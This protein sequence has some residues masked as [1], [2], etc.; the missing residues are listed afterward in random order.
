[1]EIETR[2]AGQAI[3][4]RMLDRLYSALSSGPTLNCRPGHSRQRLDLLELKA[5]Q[6]LSP[7]ETLAQLLGPAAKVTLRARAVPPPDLSDGATEEEVAAHKKVLEGYEQQTRALKKLRTIAEDA[8]EYFQDTG[9]PALYIGYPLL[10]LPPDDYGRRI[11]GRAT[12][13]VLAP[14][15]LVPV[16]LKVLSGRTPGVEIRCSETGADRLIPNLALLAWVERQTGRRLPELDTDDSGENAFGELGQI[17]QALAEAVGVQPLELG[18]STEIVRAPRSEPGETCR[19]VASAVI[20]LYPLPNQSILC[21]VRDMVEG[22]VPEGPINRFLV[23][24]SNALQERDPSD[25][26]LRGLRNIRQERCI[27]YADPCQ[28]RAV[29][30]ARESQVLVVHGPPGTGKS[31]TIANVIGDHLA[32]GQRVLM[33]CDKRTALDVVHHR[34]TH[35]GLGHL[36]AVV[37][38]AQRDRRDLYLQ[39]REQLDRLATAE[40]DPA[41][42]GRLRQ[43]DEELES[44]HAEMQ[45]YFAQLS[46]RPRPDAMTFTELAGLWVATYG[47][48]LNTVLLPEESFSQTRPED[49]AGHQAAIREALDRGLRAGFAESPW[50]DALGVRLQ[51][52]VRLPVQQVKDGVGRVAELATAVDRTL[53]PDLLPFSVDHCPKAQGSA[54]GELARRLD[55]AREARVRF[56]GWLSRNGAVRASLNELDLAAG[57]MTL[58]S[59]TPDDRELRLSARDVD[60]S[61]G[62]VNRDLQTLSEYRKSMGLWYGA[63]Q[64]GIR[65]SGREVL[66]RFGLGGSDAEAGRLMTFLQVQRATHLLADTCRS[67][68]VMLE[69]E[70]DLDQPGPVLTAA[71]QNR[72]A[73]ET[74]QFLAE[75]PELQPVSEQIRHAL[76]G[77]GWDP[78]LAGL[79][80]SAPRAEALAELDS[81]VGL[82]PVIS[83][84]WRRNLLRQACESR[85]VEGRFAALA[86]GLPQLEGIVRALDIADSLP[87]E[88]NKALRNRLRAGLDAEAGYASLLNRVVRTELD[89]R[90]AETPGLLEK[91]AERLDACQTRYLE[92][93]AIKRTLVL[94]AV[95]FRWLTLQK[96][97]LLATTGSR[98]NGLGASLKRRLMVRGKDALRLRQVVASGRDTP[99]GDPL[100]DLRPVWMASPDT[101]AQVFPREPLF[102]VVIFDEASQCRLEEAL[103]VLTRARRV[104]VAGDPKQLP[105]TRFFESAVVESE[106][107]DFES[108]QELFEV[109][110]SEVEDLLSAA[111]NLE[112]DE[113]YL[114]VH[115][116]SQNSALIDFSNQSFY[117]SRLQPI[118]GHPR[119][120]AMIAPVRMRQVE[121]VYDKR[122]NE[123][124]AEEV[125]RIVN[126]LLQRSEPPSIGVACFNLVQKALIQ[127]RLN[128][129]AEQDPEFSARLARARTRTGRDSF[130]G[131]FVKNLENVQGD[132][133]DVVLI[134]TT[135]GPDAKGRF[136][137]RFGPLGMPG[138]ARRLNV[139]VTRARQEIILIT[140]IPGSVYRTEVEVP[141]GRQP[142]GAWH[143]FA[144]LRYAEELE[145]LFEEHWRRRREATAARRGEVKVY[146]SQT[147]CS[148]TES[149]ASRLA[150]QHGISSEAYWGGDGFCIDLALLH[151]VLP[152]D[153]TL[154]VL[155]DSTRFALAPDP[156]EWDAFRTAVLQSQGWNVHR[157][158]TPHFVRDPDRALGTL[159]Q[160]VDKEVA[161]TAPAVEE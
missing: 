54:R 10:S 107:A 104:L 123:R 160:E 4:S 11:G 42:D 64:F 121:G 48:G 144:Y 149:L 80:A 159:L 110:Q 29:S 91:D 112:I 96:Q 63:L 94:Q 117:E 24:D 50:P 82:C 150:A 13:R 139:L 74:L 26:L 87:A 1:M 79:Q 22:S 125:V 40:P 153:V 134:S 21:D 39:I 90:L 148:F 49:L 70:V 5:L 38:D 152:Q 76:A 61:L 119:N 140:S 73:L 137:R 118:P 126:E 7:G 68:L 16:Q 17:V 93:Q 89:R 145:K 155:C 111:L 120:R 75:S 72:Q 154:G 30:L 131:L 66:G 84:G 130:E 33:V 12:S 108:D 102:D 146:E 92:L 95:L 133:R 8:T 141:S 103:P 129:A 65:K 99:D 59:E 143:L 77:E 101:V 27:T 67:S 88:L 9:V 138:G 116:R 32:R 52:F 100:F 105:P 147:P 106:G 44:L 157:I 58:L 56:A 14:L 25:R 18:P 142:S 98:L 15:A 115:Y 2:P 86:S 158:W 23:A 127:E 69:D 31:Q 122:A 34:L 55:G 19:I 6:D 97:R 81:A 124:E 47:T 35:M 71:R 78:L 51:D 135:F 20:G 132:E 57:H 53:H 46:S 136:Y 114:D 60:L 43:A 113:A 36:C 3:L 28:S 41:A 83:Q 85:A 156:A 128:E 109:Q 151:P 45:Q 37:H 161:R 62:S